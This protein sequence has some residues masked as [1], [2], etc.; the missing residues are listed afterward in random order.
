VEEVEEMIE[1][2]EEEDWEPS[3]YMAYPGEVDQ[4]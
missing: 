1:K 3:P 2:G 4:A